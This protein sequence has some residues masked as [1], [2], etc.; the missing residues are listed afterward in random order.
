MAQFGNY[1]A[2]KVT[3][4]EVEHYTFYGLEGKPTLKVRPATRHNT[5]FKN[6]HDK[7]D[8]QFTK[9]AR[10][11]SPTADRESVRIIAKIMAEHVVVDWPTPPVDVK[12][13]PVKFTQENCFEF[14]CA[15]P[16]FMLTGN[17]NSILNFCTNPRNFSQ[18]PVDNDDW[19]AEDVEDVADMG[20]SSAK[21]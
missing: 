4:A 7:A 16:D 15:I 20:K 1:E 21:D 14:L 2:L 10:Q 8:A 18:L 13:N 3:G 19:T 11:N 17:A 9:L 6:A 5:D 12:G